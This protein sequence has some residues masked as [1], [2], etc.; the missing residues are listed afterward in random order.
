MIY[1]AKIIEYMDLKYNCN[2]KNYITNESNLYE[3]GFYLQYISI[4]YVKIDTYFYFINL[5][6]WITIDWN[7][8]NKI[9]LIRISTLSLDYNIILKIIEYII[10]YLSC[11][12]ISI[13]LKLFFM[14]ITLNNNCYFHTSFSKLQRMFFIKSLTKNWSE[15]KKLQLKSHFINVDLLILP[16]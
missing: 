13:I 5:I 11:R 2:F 3:T 16:F 1:G 12:D 15:K 14:E 7:L 4:D 8:L 10:K 6:N 9:K